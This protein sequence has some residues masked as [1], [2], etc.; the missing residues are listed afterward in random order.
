M[1]LSFAVNRNDIFL[2]LCVHLLFLGDV[3]YT[4]RKESG[5]KSNLIFLGT[6]TL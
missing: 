2:N 5:L 4:R 3:G 1:C 6:S